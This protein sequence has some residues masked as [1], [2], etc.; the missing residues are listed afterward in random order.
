MSVDDDIEALIAR[1]PKLATSKK[2]VSSEEAAALIA[3]DDDL[4][5]AVTIYQAANPDIFE[6]WPQERT[7]LIQI[8]K[9]IIPFR[10]PYGAFYRGEPDVEADVPA[11]QRG[12]RSWSVARDI[13]EE[14]ARE[15]HGI[16]R[17]L[18]GP[19]KGVEIGDILSWR[20]YL[21]DESHYPGMQSEYLI[22][23]SSKN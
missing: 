8:L 15:S 18:S 2:R 19:V 7:K 13:A 4:F 5:N 22:L 16:V 10:S 17:V 11:T 21:R 20:S 9:R 14:F 1:L 6:L 12:F 3:N 23:D